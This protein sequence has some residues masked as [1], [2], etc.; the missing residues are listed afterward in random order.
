MMRD[1]KILKGGF[2][3][4]RIFFCGFVLTLIWIGTGIGAIGLQAPVLTHGVASGDV[5]PTSALIW[6]RASGATTL[7]VEYSTSD[8]FANSL[9]SQPLAMTEQSDFTGQITLKELKPA[10][11]YF[12]RVIPGATGQAQSGTFLTAPAP[13][14]AANVRFVWSA[15]L[16]G[17]SMC[18]QPE[19][20]IFNKLKEAEP[21]FFV[22][23]G[24]TIYADERCPAP[25]NVPGS[26]FVAKTLPEFR[27]KHQYNRADI[28]YQ[29]ALASTS[30]LVNWDDHEVNN[31]FS[32]TTEP[33]TPLGLQA[34]REYFPITRYAEPSR[35]YGSF[36][37][38]KHLEI[39][40]LDARLYRS[41]NSAPDGPTKTML[42][43]EQLTWFKTALKN[44]TATWKMISSPDQISAPN[45]CPLFCDNWAN[46]GGPTGFEREFADISNHIL[47]NQIKNVI[48]LTADGHYAQVVSYD[49]NSDQNP[50]YYEFTAGP[51]SALL[52][53]V[54]ALD[55]T[56]NPTLL[57]GDATYPNFGLISINGASGKLELEFIDRGGESRYKK[58]FEPK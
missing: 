39:F 32:G 25:P 58:S 4:R 46:G 20:F 14:A 11:R 28:P 1:A 41:S 48:W 40:V 50:D 17:Q 34:F 3:M 54:A 10:T 18:R 26:D 56:F 33:L 19:Y 6:A 38:G 15:D 12:Y 2:F 45:N 37:W 57:Y 9:K 35:M 16:G 49:P 31:D 52:F 24:D 8:D 36:R 43:A 53:F 51:L 5:T 55:P 22:Y 47:Q 29:K 13:D 30:L 23:Q 44:S 42:G 21:D 7:T 27:L